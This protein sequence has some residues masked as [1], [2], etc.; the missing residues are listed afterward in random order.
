MTAT[1]EDVIT[2]FLC[3]DVMPGRGVDQALP[4]PCPPGLHESYVTSAQEYVELAERVHGPINRPVS[5]AY[6]WGE[7]LE[8][9]DA[10]RP[11]TRIV[12][13]ETAITRSERPWPGKGI[14]YRMSPEN[15]GLLSAARIDCCA[16]ANNHVIDWGHGGLTDTLRTLDALGIRHAGAGATR[17]EAEAP[18]VID[19]GEMG[20]VLVVAFATRSSGVP[21]SWAAS[22]NT[23]GVALLP[24]LSPA[25][26]AHIGERLR[27]VKRP[28]DIAVVSLHWGGN[29]EFEI[30]REQRE[31]AH[32]LVDGAG[33][34]VV[35]GHSSHHVKGIEVHAGRLILYG[36]GD[37]LDDY[38]GIGGYEAFRGDL[39]V[40]YF[41]TLDRRSGRLVSLRLLP[42]RMERFRV[43]R[44]GGADG[45]V[46]A[47]MLAR[48][49]R[50][51]GTSVEEQKDGSLELIWPH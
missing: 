43:C 30:T 32:A 4:H 38:E 50:P 5:L 41:V 25:T 15:A 40:M 49:G 24:D 47:A 48:E 12:N 14:N 22:A 46:L 45:R 31:F 11:A 35:H 13:L 16:L 21:D 44:A 10:A 19:L 27:R 51:F 17:E 29:W 20:R 9:L 18:A 39:G 2:L 42:T 33:A 3:G 26:A 37:F 28:Q 7:A 34:D 6:P 8:A 36:C 23:A 1:G